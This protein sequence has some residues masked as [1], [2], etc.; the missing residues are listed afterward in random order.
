MKKNNKDFKYLNL[1]LTKKELKKDNNLKKRLIV[2]KEVLENKNNCK[3][4]GH[5]FTP[6]EELVWTS[7][8]NKE[9]LY[10]KINVA[11]SYNGYVRTC[12]KCG[13]QEVINHDPAKTKTKLK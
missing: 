11:K 7:L 5:I 4:T 8:N 10:S 2:L 3:E 9:E 12:L 1:E 13:Y 6:W